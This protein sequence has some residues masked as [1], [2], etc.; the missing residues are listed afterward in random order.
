MT[1]LKIEW[2]DPLL[3]VLF[4]KS[5]QLATSDFIDNDKKSMSAAKDRRIKK[6]EEELAAVH[7]D[8]L[9]FSRDQEEF[10]QGVTKCE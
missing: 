10:T 9:D 2:E 5:G 7:A 8:S 3:L 1:P 6:L 4:S